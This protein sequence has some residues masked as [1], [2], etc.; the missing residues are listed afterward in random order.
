MS[1]SRGKSYILTPKCLWNSGVNV[2]LLSLII[3]SF[4]D[5]VV[6]FTPQEEVTEKS[7]SPLILNSISH[8]NFS[9]IRILAFV[10]HGVGE[11]YFDVKTTLHDWGINI[12][13][14]GKRGTVYSCNNHQNS[15]E[16][17]VDLLLQ[18][19]ND[20]FLLTYDCLFIPSG[21]YWASVAGD[22]IVTNFIERC[23]DLGLFISSMCVGTPILGNSGDIVKNTKVLCHNNGASLITQAEGIDVPHKTTISH[24]RIITGDIGGGFIGGGHSVAPY[25]DFCVAMLKNILNYSF[26]TNT[27][28]IPFDPAEKTHG[29]A[30]HEITVTTTSLEA[31][32]NE[33]PEMNSSAIEE[34]RLEIIYENRDGT[35]EIEEVDLITKSDNVFSANITL[36]KRKDATISIELENG[37]GDVEIR[38]IDYQS[39]D[40]IPGFSYFGIIGS[41]LALSTILG[42]Q[43]T[44]KHSLQKKM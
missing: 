18:N 20:T 3:L 10:D 31:F 4:S 23:Y 32:Y 21:S 6:A 14:I 29:E 22:F 35:R 34:V 7:D 39:S 30:T 5:G 42:L 37:N 26:L 19:L 33:I 27:S 2:F 1:K 43:G 13:T 25:K 40:S 28:L 12:T 38:A 41:L 36:Q 24:N 9:E 11:N 17:A 8:D 16:I 15:Q 44:Q